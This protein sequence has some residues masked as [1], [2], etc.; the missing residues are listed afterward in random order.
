MNTLVRLGIFLLR[1]RLKAADLGETDAESARAVVDESA[2]GGTWIAVHHYEP[3][4]G[5]AR[6]EVFLFNGGGFLTPPRIVARVISELST[7]ED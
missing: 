1:A 3:R 4:G 7:G 5:R 6:G 2:L